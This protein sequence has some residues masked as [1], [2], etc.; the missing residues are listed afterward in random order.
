MLRYK[1]PTLKP[2]PH[3]LASGVNVELFLQPKINKE[4]YY[5]AEH[6]LYGSSRLGIK[7]YWPNHYQFYYEYGPNNTWTSAV[8]GNQL[9]SL[10]KPW[11]SSP[12]NSIISANQISPYG[13]SNVDA[14]VS[15]RIIGL[16]HFELTNHLG[17][18]MAVLTDKIVDSTFSNAVGD[19]LPM[20]SFRK[21]SLYASYDYYPFGM[22]MPNRYYED[23]TIQCTPVTKTTYSPYWINVL[24]YTLA[25]P[26]Q[27]ADFT[28]LPLSTT[29]NINETEQFLHIVGSSED[30]TE[31]TTSF[32]VSN[33]VEA[34]KTIKLHCNLTNNGPH[35]VTISIKQQNAN[36]D[37]V[38][39][40]STTVARETFVELEA[41]PTANTALKVEF[42]AEQVDFK[43]GPLG[44]IRQDILTGSEIVTICN[45]NGFSNDYRFGFNGQMKDNEVAGTG[46]HNTAEFWEY[47]TRLG[48][49]WNLDPID[50]VNVSNYV[51]FGDNPVLN[52]DKLGDKKVKNSDLKSGKASFETFDTKRDEIE[53]KKVTIT[54]KRLNPTPADDSKANGVDKEARSLLRFDNTYFNQNHEI[55]NFPFAYGNDEYDDPVDRLKDFLTGTGA[56]NLV[57]GPNT[58]WTQ[59]LKSLDAVREGRNLFYSKYGGQ[60]GLFG[61]ESLTDFIIP[62]SP[63]PFVPGGGQFYK[64]FRNLHKHFVGS[65]ALNIFTSEDGKRMIFII[66]NSTSK[67]SFNFHAPWIN[68]IA[69]DAAF[70]GFDNPQPSQST[71]NGIWIWSEPVDL[72]RLRNGR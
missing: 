30:P 2:T 7:N 24:S 35:Y 54:A 9:L 10:H 18:V 64:S 6:H 20:S 67:W 50:Q 71:I 3:S 63:D 44:F 17:N 25:A 47:D 34:F 51:T 41:I 37:W 19:N 65:A 61:T 29:A 46:N 1:K 56:T 53:L 33:G 12:Y 11:N 43:I 52:V 58:K 40:A 31:S 16:K 36:N 5:L 28:T 13:H 42:S 59:E 14:V 39:I 60:I 70:A 8:A 26:E 62:W 23:N 48:R 72:N 32:L 27:L 21:S 49:R 69:R 45:N 4:E 55:N 68:N 38:A 22:L 15:N 66:A 57:Y